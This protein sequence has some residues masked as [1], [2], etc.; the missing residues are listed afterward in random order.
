MH[1]DP[2]IRF[3]PGLMPPNPQKGDAAPPPDAA[4]EGVLCIPLPAADCLMNFGTIYRTNPTPS[5]TNKEAHPVSAHLGPGRSGRAWDI[6]RFSPAA[7]HALVASRTRSGPS[8]RGRPCVAGASC[9]CSSLL[10]GTTTKARRL[11]DAKGPPRGFCIGQ[12]QDARTTQAAASDGAF[13]TLGLGPSCWLAFPPRRG[14][15]SRTTPGRGCRDSD[16]EVLACRAAWNVVPGIWNVR[17]RPGGVP[18][19]GERG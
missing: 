3:S 18:V 10:L 2:R 7:W 11:Q 9:P 17:S 12:P 15:I 19:S 6:C 16:F 8:V 14:R 13:R 1:G 5:R 4:Q